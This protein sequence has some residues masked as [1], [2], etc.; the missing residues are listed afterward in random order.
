LKE[1]TITIDNKEIKAIEGE[2]LL[3]RALEEDFFIP[4]LCSIKGVSPAKASCR[5]CYVEVEGAPRPVTSCTTTISDGMVV[6]T[7]TEAVDRLVASGF[8]M[9]MSIHRLDCKYCPGNKR[10]ALQNIA[11]NRKVS[12]RVK[13]I[14][15]IEPDFPIDQSRPDM[16]FNPNHCVLCGQC[17]HVCNKVVN[18]G[19]LDFTKRGLDTMVGTFNGEPLLDQDCGD[20]VACVE[21]CPVGA[22]YIRKPK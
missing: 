8:E 19:V 14:P 17:V 11:K 15:K 10:C 20:C 9:L 22:L 6:K 4:N 1:V 5:L 13:R 3:Y 18:K 21:V 2:T 16:G 12:L 7:R